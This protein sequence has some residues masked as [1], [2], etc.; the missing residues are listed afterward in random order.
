M[1]SFKDNAGRE[2]FL[3]GDFLTYDRVRAATGVKLYDIT[4]ESRESLT[5][6]ADPMTLGGVLWTMIES[7]ATDRGVTVEDFYGAFDGTVA[8]EAH[9]ALVSEMIFFCHPNQRKLLERTYQAV[10][11]AEA[12][13]V[14]KAE[15]M[16][17]EMEREIDD[18]VNRLTFGDSDTSSPESWAVGPIIGRSENFN[19]PS[20]A[21]S[22]SSGTIP[23]R[24]SRK[25]RKSTA[26]PSG[27]LDRTPLKKSTR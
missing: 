20:K 21:G 18:L 2:W 9:N 13:A 26:I 16:L 14:A 4:S 12:K 10:R 11:E 15:K 27:A 8:H 25:S 23:L 19:G 1:H 5:Q 22:E 7:Q 3:K 6:I 24:S 17:P